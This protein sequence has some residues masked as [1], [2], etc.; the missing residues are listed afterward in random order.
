MPNNFTFKASGLIKVGSQGN[1]IKVIPKRKVSV[2]E[3]KH[4][5]KVQNKVEKMKQP[6]VEQERAI[7]Q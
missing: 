6:D 3:K 7:Q 1:E 2:N 4:L 5:L